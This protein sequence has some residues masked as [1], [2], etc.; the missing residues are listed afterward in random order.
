[1]ACGCVCIATDVPGNRE[2]IRDKENGLLVR[3]KDSRSLAKAI[4]EILNDKNL[5]TGLSEKARKTVEKFSVE[6][7]ENTLYKEIELVKKIMEGTTNV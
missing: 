7:T 2:L 5:R 6:N 4:I 3:P 1:M